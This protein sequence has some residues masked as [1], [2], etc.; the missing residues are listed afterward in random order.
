MTT[1]RKTKLQKTDVSRPK[2]IGLVM[3]ISAMG[4]K[5]TEK[6]WKKVCK[7]LSK[8]MFKQ[9]TTKMVS[10]RDCHGFITST[11]INNLNNDD[12]VICDITCSNPNVMFE[13]GVRIAFD[14][15]VVIVKEKDGKD[16][17]FDIRTIRYIEYPADLNSTGMKKFFSELKKKVLEVFKSSKDK[18]KKTLL[19]Q[20]SVSRK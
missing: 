14:K 6:H 8:K 10:E 18:K 3:P 2:T 11:I 20:Y 13:L 5:H 19:Q 12:V 17:V 16:S 4:E 15:P 7:C 1:D 9:S